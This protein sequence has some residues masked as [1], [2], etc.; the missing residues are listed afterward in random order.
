MLKGCQ[1]HVVQPLSGNSICR[2]VPL[3][4]YKKFLAKKQRRTLSLSLCVGLQ[5]LSGSLEWDPYV[6]WI[7][8]GLHQVT[9]LSG[10]KMG[11]SQPRAHIF[12]SS[13]WVHCFLMGDEM[14]SPP[15]SS[16]CGTALPTANLHLRHKKKSFCSNE[17]HQG[18]FWR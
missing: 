8:L 16:L 10:G 6:W 14:F 3:K 4:S 18:S 5:S 12:C 17:N 7:G 13:L 2:I 15:S 1:L 9:G 11:E